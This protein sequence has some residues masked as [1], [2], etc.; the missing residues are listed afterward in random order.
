MVQNV[1]Q[2]ARPAEFGRPGGLLHVVLQQLQST[3]LP[4]LL[5]YA[6]ILDP[7]AAY[8]R[9]LATARD[10]NPGSDAFQTVSS[11][12]GGGGDGILRLCTFDGKQIKER[13]LLRGHTKTARDAAFAPDGQTLVSVGEDAQI[14]LWD[15]DSGALKQKWELRIPIHAVAFSPDSRHFVIANANG[16]LYVF[17]LPD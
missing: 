8:S 17:R 6:T 13:T 1:G 15:G 7:A 5:P 14:I 2:A 12:L 10:W 9:P 11:V 16:S 3:F 4:V